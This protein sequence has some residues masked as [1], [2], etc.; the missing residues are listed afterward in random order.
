MKKLLIAVLMMTSAGAIA[1][2]RPRLSGACR[3]EV[4][5]L[6]GEPRERGV[7][8]ACLGGKV[9]E[10]SSDCRTEMLERILT[11]QRKAAPAG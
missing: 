8:R 7:V 4:V 10:L 9:R 5:K 6:C 2:E 1:H 3:A 11:R